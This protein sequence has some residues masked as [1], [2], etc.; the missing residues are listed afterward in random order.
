MFSNTIDFWRFNAGTISGGGIIFRTELNHTIEHP[1]AI[2][3]LLISRAAFCVGYPDWIPTGQL[4]FKIWKKFPYERV[5]IL[6]HERKLMWIEC[7][8]SL[9]FIYLVVH[10]TKHG[11]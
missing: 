3:T 4:R 2:L 1:N 5:T 11:V 6:T 10:T 7:L 8:K 9:D